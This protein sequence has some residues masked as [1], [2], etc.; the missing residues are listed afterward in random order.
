MHVDNSLDNLGNKKINNSKRM[1]VKVYWSEIDLNKAVD[2]LQSKNIRTYIS[3]RQGSSTNFV[4]RYI[5]L[6]EANYFEK[7]VS[8]LNLNNL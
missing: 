1:A 8:L 4:E 3:R 2:E 7:A 6:V 5:L